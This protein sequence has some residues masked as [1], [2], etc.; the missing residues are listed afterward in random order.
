MDSIEVKKLV[1][2]FPKK[3]KK[4]ELIAVNIRPKWCG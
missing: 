4:G 1:K 3:K 2:K